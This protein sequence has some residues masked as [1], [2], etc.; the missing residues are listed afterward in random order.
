MR[1]KDLLYLLVLICLSP[2]TLRAEELR[3]ESKPVGATIE[4]N[5]C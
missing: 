4:I 2:L 3:I 1:F 5:G